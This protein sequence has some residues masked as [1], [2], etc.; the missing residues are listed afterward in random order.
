MPLDNPIFDSDDL[1]PRLLYEDSPFW[2]GRRYEELGTRSNPI[3]VPS[4]S[5]SPVLHNPPPGP[6]IKPGPTGSGTLNTT[7]KVTINKGR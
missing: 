2:Q 6:I 4:R 1:L 5:P 7:G 3:L